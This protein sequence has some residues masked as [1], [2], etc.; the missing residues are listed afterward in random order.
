MDRYAGIPG[1]AL[2]ISSN[3]EKIILPI[4]NTKGLWRLF[5]F[6]PRSSELKQDLTSLLGSFDLAEVERLSLS[7]GGARLAIGSRNRLLVLDLSTMQIIFKAFARFPALSSD[8]RKVGF[9]DEGHTLHVRDL[10]TGAETTMPGMFAYGVGAWSPDGTILLA[11]GWIA[12][13]WNKSLCAVDTAERQTV[14]LAKLGEGDFG[15]RCFWI[16][17]RLLSWE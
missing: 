16:S 17:R 6:D 7:G 1:T 15:S 8:G 14:A 4:V 10:N 12:L 3:L 11:G 13:S 9:V 2:A 5:V